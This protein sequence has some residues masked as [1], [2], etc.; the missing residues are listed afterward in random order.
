MDRNLYQMVSLQIPPPLS[1]FLWKRRGYLEGGGIWSNTLWFLQKF[2]LKIDQIWGFVAF[3]QIE[4]SGRNFCKMTEFQSWRKNLFFRL[5]T[6]YRYFSKN[7][8]FFEKNQ[9]LR[10]IIYHIS[11]WINFEKSEKVFKYIF[12][13][14]FFIKISAIW[15]R[16]LTEISTCP[17]PTK[18]QIWPTLTRNFC[19]GRNSGQKFVVEIYPSY[20]STPP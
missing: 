8:T 1:D 5:V 12:D 6:K 19:K 7:T 10:E 17:K 9:N 14:L 15:Q 20:I 13:E 2:I 3:G 4:I 11:S 18:I 16:F